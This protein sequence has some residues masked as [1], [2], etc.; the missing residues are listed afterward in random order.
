MPSK[1][2][3]PPAHRDA[4]AE[5]GLDDLMV[6]E[7][8]QRWPGTLPIF[9]RY[10]LACVGCVMARFERLAEV[11]RIYGLDEQ[12][13]LHEVRQAVHPQEQAP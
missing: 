10:R 4:R 3:I 13:F 6:A 5:P 2:L 9:L 1:Q 7:V 8:L 12:R 11:P